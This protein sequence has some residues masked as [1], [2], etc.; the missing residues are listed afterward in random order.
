M[1]FRSMPNSIL[2]RLIELGM[3]LL[4]PIQALAAGMDP[5]ELKRQFG[6]RLTFNGGIDTQ[7]LL[8][9][10]SEEEVR[11]STARLIN[12]VGHDGGLILAPSHVFQ[13]DVPIENIIAVY[14]TALGHRL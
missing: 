12:V 7:G 13:D 10:A 11:R 14:E 8:P 3:D 4:H 1:L 5:E 9:N 6:D 2:P